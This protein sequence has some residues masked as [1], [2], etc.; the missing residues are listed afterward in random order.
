[1]SYQ[2][3]VIIILIICIFLVIGAYILGIEVG[4][5]IHLKHYSQ[6]RDFH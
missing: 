6:I 1:M 5:T 4:S 3:M 2:I